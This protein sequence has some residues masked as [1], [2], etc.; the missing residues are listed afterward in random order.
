MPALTIG[1]PI[2][3][4]ALP[5]RARKASTSISRMRR[6]IRGCVPTAQSVRPHSGVRADLDV[7]RH[8]GVTRSHPSAALDASDLDETVDVSR[9]HRLRLFRA[10]WGFH[11]RCLGLGQRGTD[12][13]SRRR[14]RGAQER[15][16]GPYWAIALRE[17]RQTFGARRNWRRNRILA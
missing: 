12:Q 3:P 11:A 5:Q 4:P 9:V 6:H 16:A 14:G 13:V 8:L 17:L 2:S 1:R 15:A 7:Q 10:L